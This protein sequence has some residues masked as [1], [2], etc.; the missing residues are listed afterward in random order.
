PSA[1]ELEELYAIT[2]GQTLT[3]TLHDMVLDGIEAG[4]NLHML[5]AEIAHIVPL[6][7]VLP[8]VTPQGIEG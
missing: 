3:E 7:P 8:D 2:D 1:G 4:H 6:W 5:Y